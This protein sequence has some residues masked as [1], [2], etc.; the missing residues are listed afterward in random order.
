V[1]IVRIIFSAVVVAAAASAGL[2]TA[3]AAP[4]ADA[5]ATVRA[6]AVNAATVNAAAVTAAVVNAAAVN[7]VA[8]GDSYSS[9]LGAGDYLS[10]SGSCDRSADAYPEQWA[11]ANSPATFTSAAC[12]GATTADVLSSQVSALSA[13][14]TLV[15]ITI[16]G[17]DAGFSSVMETCALS[18]SSTCLN[19]VAAAE[20]FVAD[21]LPARLD[22]T[23]QTIR[24]DAP[25]A[26]VI[27]LG[28]P[29]LYDLSNSGTCI[30]LSTKDRTA[31]NQGADDLDG[32]LQAAA[33]ANNDTF[34]DV[35]SQFAGHEI[36]D[37]GSWL[38]SVDIFAIS[39]CYHPTAAGQELGYLPVFSRAA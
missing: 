4:A 19:A 27:V 12:S 37:S 22:Q 24:A 7:Y 5:A 13:S 1:R 31:L 20:A 35:R 33:Q 21:Q 28:Y 11:A 16:G 14:T 32:A 8:L 23:L 6:A 34:A 26:T 18:L 17:N 39:S 2:V 25:S 10:S 9:G 36:C 3:T 29:D 38:H 30:G 15:S